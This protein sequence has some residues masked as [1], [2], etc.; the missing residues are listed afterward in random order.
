MAL[1]EDASLS[2]ASERVRFDPNGGEGRAV[3]VARVAFLG[4]GTMGFPMVRQLLKA[5]LEVRAW[6]RSGDRARPLA[7]DGAAIFEDPR[8]AAEGS[9]LVVTML[10]DASAVLDTAASALQVAKPGTVWIQMSTI[11]AEGVERCQALAERLG[12]RLVDAPVLGTRAPA[13]NGKLVVLA[14]GD[15]GA[16]DAAKPV[17]DAVGSRTLQLGPVGHGTRCKLVVNSWLI[18]V[19][20]VLAETISLAEVL[21]VD[22]QHFFDAIEGGPL[23]LPYARTKGQ[24]MVEKSFDDASFRLALTLK[25]ANLVLAAAEE[26]DL[27]VPVLRA[28]TGRLQRADQEG[29]GDED[30]AA[31]YLATAPP[32]FQ[33]NGH[34]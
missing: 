17:F 1:H 21:D 2:I 31:T 18:G 32:A 20:S 10:A 19:T 26:A 6:N 3:A 34:G 13:E 24:A 5:G 11:G 23:D 33:S 8:E 4:T 22:P 29:H 30:M 16:L 14:S 27:E 28:V 15:A 9:D 25:D 7:D 12:V